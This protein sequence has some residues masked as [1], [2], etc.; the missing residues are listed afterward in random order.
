MLL[1]FI[2]PRAD[3]ADLIA[4]TVESFCRALQNLKDSGLIVIHDARHF[5]LC[6][7]KGLKA[8]SSLDDSNLV[9]LFPN[10]R[11]D[12]RPR[13]PASDKS[14]RPSTLHRFAQRRPQD[15]PTTTH[16]TH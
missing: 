7:P 10:R 8:M 12:V 9:S 3:A 14:H 6:D 4:T 2:L 5:E 13:T 15:H 16:R 1:K 11:G